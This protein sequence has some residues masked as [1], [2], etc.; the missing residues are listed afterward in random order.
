MAVY[1][2][3]RKGRLTGKWIAEVTRH[4]E[5]RRKRFDQ[6]L[7]AERWAD[8]TKLT[9]GSQEE[10]AYTFGEIAKEGEETDRI[11]FTHNG[12]E[13]E[14]LA[15]DKCVT[16]GTKQPLH[17]TVYPERRKGRLTDIWIAEKM[18]YGK[19]VRARCDTREEA[20]R[21]LGFINDLPAHEPQRETKNMDARPV[22]RKPSHNE[23]RKRRMVSPRRMFSETEL[24]AGKNLLTAL[25]AFQKVRHTMPLQYVVAFL[26]VATDE[27]KGVVDYAKRAGVSVSVM[28]RH[29]L[30]IGERN[31][32]ME[33]GFGLVTYRAN[34]LELRKHEYFLTDKGRALL[35]KLT[36]QITGAQAH[37][38]TK[39][40]DT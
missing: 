7:E 29:L 36:R 2:E 16:A 24:D 8:F 25:Q 1:L 30:D 6:K 12:V 40:S 5:R 17:L 14:A 27:D 9:G 33:E 4:G 20:E 18:V 39:S 34:P 22:T 10:A 37:C 19:R 23:E 15:D 11:K 13:A 21:W 38:T 28:S 32:H 35:H 3:I 26:L 31:R